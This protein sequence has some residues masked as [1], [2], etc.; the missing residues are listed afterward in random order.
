METQPT[1]TLPW[2]L[3]P[4]PQRIETFALMHAWVIVAINLIG[5]AFGFWY[6]LPQ[7][8]LEPVIAWPVVPDSPVATLLI[9]LLLALYKLDRSNE[10]LNVLAFFGCIKL[11]LW[12]PYVLTVFADAFLR[13]VA[14]PPQVVALLG[15]DLAA[16]AMYGFL[17]VSHLGM[18]VEA[19][20]IHRYSDFPLGAILIA[21]SW[22][23]FN[24]LI[25]YFLPIVGTPHHT[26]LPVEPIVRGVVQHISPAHEIAAAGAIVFTLLAIVSAEATRRAK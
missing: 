1:D 26:L 24:D 2:F 6:Y 25:D 10:Y 19:F 18:V 3:E 11:G 8:R 13:T 14:P 15:S 4:I 23:G 9:A 7:F 21:A 5:T 16:T 20:L 17:L 12:T 22:Y